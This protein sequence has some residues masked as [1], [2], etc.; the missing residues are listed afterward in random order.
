MGSDGQTVSKVNAESDSIAAVFLES[1][2]GMFSGEERR[3]RGTAVFHPYRHVASE[4]FA[5]FHD[6]VVRF[7]LKDSLFQ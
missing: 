3:Q 1:I 2:Q 4:L 5:V 7:K 6:F